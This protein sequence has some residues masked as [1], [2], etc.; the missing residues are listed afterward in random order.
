MTHKRE[1]ES[2]LL[3]LVRHACAPESSSAG[4]AERLLLL[5]RHERVLLLLS[6]L[7]Y[8]GNRPDDAGH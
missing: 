3:G 7:I 2:G 4:R 8:L 5:R 6:S 1:A